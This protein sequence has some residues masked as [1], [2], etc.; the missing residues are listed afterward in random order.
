MQNSDT[1]NPSPHRGFTLVEILLV[2][3]ITSVL[4][5]GINAAFQQA[6]LLW[7]NIEAQRPVYDNARLITE[8]L[9]Q[10]ISGLYLP[11]TSET[12]KD[13][14]FELSTLPD[15]TVNLTFYTLTPSWKESLF[16]SRIVK[17][18]YSFSRD[19]ATGK[20]LLERAEQF[21]AGE[22]IIGQESSNV[23]LKGL[24]DFKIWCA[25]PDSGSSSDLWKQSY[26]S[27]RTPPKAIKVLLKWPANK[28]ISE[29]SFETS[30]LVPCQAPLTL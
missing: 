3:L 25:V 29:T 7:S 21:C 20:N 18:R 9:R 5:L 12:E 19:K 14:L 11:Q 23:I 27:E 24:S 10:E 2:M 6:H 22:K 4:V 26:S 30:I 13:N 8:T 16:S 28:D 1:N 17:I 15:G